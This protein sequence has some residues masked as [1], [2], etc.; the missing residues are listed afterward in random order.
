[1]PGLG[2]QRCRSWGGPALQGLAR[3]RKAGV[4]QEQTSRPPRALVAMRQSP[5]MVWGAWRRARRAPSLPVWAPSFLGS[6][7]API[8]H[9]HALSAAAFSQ[10][11]FLLS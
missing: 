5:E 4:R 6:L 1:M 2:T 10:P 3:W 9:S 11:L 7:F 8:R